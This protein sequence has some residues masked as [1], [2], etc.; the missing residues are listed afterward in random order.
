MDMHWCWIIR[1]YGE[2]E[3][4]DRRAKE[5][6]KMLSELHKNEKQFLQELNLRAPRLHYAISPLDHVDLYVILQLPR[7]R[8]EQ[9]ACLFLGANTA[10]ICFLGDWRILLL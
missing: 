4:D 10:V 3:V 6:N 8:S 7:S 5:V 2:E 9:L 1:A